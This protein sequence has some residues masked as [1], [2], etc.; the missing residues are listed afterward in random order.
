[1]LLFNERYENA[2]ATAQRALDEGPGVYF[3]C[4]RKIESNVR[5]GAMLDNVEGMFANRQ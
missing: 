3:V 4:R 1:M 5:I 2:L